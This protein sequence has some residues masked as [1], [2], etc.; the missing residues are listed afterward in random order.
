MSRITRILGKV[1]DAAEVTEILQHLGMQVTPD[2]DSW[3]VI[4]PSFRFDITQEIDLIEELAR[5]HG[6][7]NIASPTPHAALSMYSQPEVTLET[8]QSVLVQRDYQEAI[9]YSF[10]QPQWQAKL[11]PHVEAL[12]LANPITSDMAVMR[13]TLW[14]GLLHALL[15]N[16]KRQQSRVRLFETGLRFLPTSQGLQQ[17]AM[18]AGVVSGTRLQEQWNELL[19]PIDFYDIKADV[20]AILQTTRLNYQVQPDF[21]PALHPGQ[22]AAIYHG[23]EFLGII[24][25]LHPRLIDE[26]GLLAPVY[27]F[28]LR[29][30]PLLQ[31]K[32]IQFKEISKYPSVR[33]D[34]AVV[35][36][37]T[38]SVDKIITCIQQAA[39]EQL[40]ELKLFD[41][42]QGTGIAPQQ[43]S[44]AIALIF[45]APDRNLIDT[46]VETQIT[47]IVHSLEQ[48]FGASL[49]K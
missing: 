2:V 34:I 23:E 38:W 41:V 39:S 12:S 10:V 5:I 46:E 49:R 6:Y 48:D 14:S 9:T 22:T 43:K 31:D 21:H 42:Y 7:D 40:V 47:R 8:L 3:Q 36:D 35:V 28:E 26:L 44:L 32:L 11:T 19:Q 1:L 27:L 25:A 17:D 30:S 16:Q 13:T 37:K 18:L 24:G 45:Q 20:A 29:L 33:R 15:Y 4:L